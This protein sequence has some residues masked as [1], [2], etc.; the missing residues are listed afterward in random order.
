MNKYILILCV[1]CTG[2]AHVRYVPVMPQIDRSLLVKCNDV[3]YIDDNKLTA[4]IE[5]VMANNHEHKLCKIRLDAL[6]NYINELE[7]KYAFTS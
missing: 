2:C 3:V 1:I 7:K 4:F 6:I 5:E